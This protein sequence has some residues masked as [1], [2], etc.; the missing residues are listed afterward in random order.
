MII[1]KRPDPPDDHLQEGANVDEAEKSG[2]MVQLVPIGTKG[3]TRPDRDKGCNSS[4]SG[5]R[6][7]LVD[8][9][10]NV[11]KAAKSGRMVQLVPIGTKGATLDEGANVDEAAKSG[12]RVQLV[13]IGTKGATRRRGSKR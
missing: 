1:C 4:R 11:D 10:A 8:E 2:R 3:A 9:G 5:R 6:V 7:Q 13:P 12:R